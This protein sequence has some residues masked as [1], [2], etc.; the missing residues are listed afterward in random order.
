[1]LIEADNP[2]TY[3][4]I[5]QSVVYQY[6]SD[7]LSSVEAQIKEKTLDNDSDVHCAIENYLLPYKA[8]SLYHDLLKIVTDYEIACYHATKVL[9]RRQISDHGLKVN[10]WSGYSE[11]LRKALDD[12][13]VEDADEVMECVHKEYERKYGCVGFDPR[14]C[15]FSSLDLVD[16]GN[17][18]GY[19]Q[20]CQNIGG[21]L[22]RW[23]LADTLP[24]AFQILKR[25]GSQL[26]VKFSLPF[27][28]IATYQQDTIL[29]Q[30]VCYYAAK[31]FWG[32]DYAVQY[33]GMTYKNVA[34]NHILELIEY[35]KEV[36]YE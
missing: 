1:M 30:F 11:V 15:F 29:Y 31:Y 34:P 6:I 35:G 3:P 36:D 16:G 28:D 21:E 14:L 13:N 32:W 18:A 2:S 4:H 25:N 27:R 17:F 12:L 33:D 10:E 20:F 19:D 9:D 7:N 23:A 22:A 5:M 26:I 8:E 24:E